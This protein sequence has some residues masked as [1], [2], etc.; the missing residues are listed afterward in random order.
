MLINVKNQNLFCLEGLQEVNSLEA[1]AKEFGGATQFHNIPFSFTTEAEFV[2]T[3][4]GLNSLKIL[5]PSTMDVDTPCDNTVYVN[6]VMD[7]LHNLGMGVTQFYD[8]KGA[9]FSEECGVVEEKVTVIEFLR[10]NM[11]L[12]DFKSLVKV[13]EYIKVAMKQE[14]V[15]LIVNDTL[16]II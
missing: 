6:Q 11:G 3:Y 9:W 10:D 12:K 13:A 2:R 7:R 5:V 15:S 14:G 4:P 1:G 16:V 8:T